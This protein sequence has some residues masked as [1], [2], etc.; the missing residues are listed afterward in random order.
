MPLFDR[1]RRDRT[2]D[3]MRSPMVATNA[4]PSRVGLSSLDAYDDEL[5]TRKVWLAN[6]YVDAALRAIADDLARMP[7]RAGPD[8]EARQ[9]HNPRSPLAMLLG[10]APGGPNPATSPRQ[11]WK[12]TVTQR[13]ALGRFA[14]ELELDSRRRPIHVWPLV[15]RRLTP[16]PGDQSAWFSAFDYAT[17]TKG[18]VTLQP[19]EVVYSWVPHPDDFRRWVSPLQAARLDVEVMV[20]QNRYDAA[21]IR[22]GNVPAHIVVHEEFAEDA[23]TDAFRAQFTSEHQG[24]ENAGKTAFA[25][26]PFGSQLSAKDAL[27]VVTLGLSPKDTAAVERYESKLR[28]SLVALGVPL[29]RLGILTGRTFSNADREMETYWQSTIWPLAEELADAVNMQ[30][31]PRLGKGDLAGWFDPSGI[32]QLRPKPLL[33]LPTLT[34][35]VKAEL[36]SKDEG[37]A[38]IGYAGPAPDTAT[39]DGTQLQDGT[40]DDGTVDEDSADAAARTAPEPAPSIDPAAVR[41]SARRA[42]RTRQQATARTIARQQRARAEIDAH[43]GT[44]EQVLD[45]TMADHFTEQRKAVLARLTGNRGV[46]S[47]RRNELRAD[48]VFDDDYWNRRLSATVEPVFRQVVAMAGGRLAADVGLSF[49]LHAPNVDAFV[50]SRANQLAGPVTNTTYRAIQDALVEGL[51]AGEGIPQLAARIEHLFDVTWAGRSTVVARTEVISAYNGGTTTAALMFGPGVVTGMQWLATGDDRTRPAHIA[52]SGQTIRLGEAFVVGGERLAYPGDP[53]GSAD[54]IVQCRCTTLPLTKRDWDDAGGR[55]AHQGSVELRTVE[56]LV[57][58]AALGELEW[59]EAIRE[60]V[61]S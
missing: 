30:L 31:A 54:N 43:V 32:P 55:A 46:S 16:V 18:T 24:P 37:R 47:H 44:L 59:D 34:E 45:A 51:Q 9:D 49:D 61:A 20:L 8:P 13:M 4:R 50:L 42:T 36:I 27:E 14:W 48:A 29:G 40:G 41:R 56:Q 21:F 19:D 1:F 26:R 12:W 17:D 53:A 6:V 11:L 58:R 60:L 33:A 35:A 7:F 2:P 39:D 57:V 25:S 10:P 38:E 15:A 3:D 5:L 52:A 28:A 22:N 23:D